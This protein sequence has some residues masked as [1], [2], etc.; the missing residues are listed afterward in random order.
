MKR[1]KKLKEALGGLRHDP[2]EALRLARIGLATAR[3]RYLLRIAGP[4]C[5]FGTGN[6]VINAANVRIGAN[7]LFQDS[8]YIRA[9]VNGRVRIGDRVA[10]NSFVQLYGHG[11]I[12]IADEAQIGPGTIITT[13][14]HDYTDRNLEASFNPIVIGRRVWIGANVT[15]IGGVTIGDG[16][17]VGAG[18]VVIR[19]IPPHSLAVGVPARVIR[20]LREAVESGSAKGDLQHEQCG[21]HRASRPRDEAQWP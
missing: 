15:I 9:G 4:G 20:P 11:G 2:A 3:F 13:T 14:G 10:I 12:D 16:A 5:V 17:V 1:G 18:A 19:D 6:R 21:D 7:C 8:I